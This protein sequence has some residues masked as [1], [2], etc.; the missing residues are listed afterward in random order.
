LPQVALLKKGDSVFI[1]FDQFDNELALK[2]DGKSLNGVLRKKD[3]SGRTIPVNAVFGETYRF[4]NNGEKPGTD[5]SGKY[6]AT[7][8]GRN[9]TDE[10]KWA[11]SNSK[12]VSY[13]QHF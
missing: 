6:E 5:I 8:T 1:A 4:A 10:K 7:F 12:A 2:V 9:G 3:L 11:Y 13:Q